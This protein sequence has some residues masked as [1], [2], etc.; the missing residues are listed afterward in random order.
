MGLYGSEIDQD[1]RNNVKIQFLKY[2]RFCYKITFIEQKLTFYI[3]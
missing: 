2:R 1:T 3:I